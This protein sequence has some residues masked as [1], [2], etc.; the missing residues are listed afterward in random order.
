MIE[1]DAFGKIGKYRGV[2]VYRQTKQNYLNNC[3]FDNSTCIYWIE[4][5][6]G[7]LVMNNYILAIFDGKYIDEDKY[8]DKYEYVDEYID[9]SE[10]CK[11]RALQRK[12]IYQ[13]IGGNYNVY[14]Y[15]KVIDK[16]MVSDEQKVIDCIV[17]SKPTE[18][19]GVVYKA[20]EDM[21][22]GS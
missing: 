6:N 4:D 12:R 13:Q 2:S 22:K 18:Q 15:Y 9:E 20:L 10:C 14:K 8:E 19:Q 5:D 21:K 16:L 7:Y 17:E 1:S 3:L 11:Y